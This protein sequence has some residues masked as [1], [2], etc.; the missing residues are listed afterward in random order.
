[1]TFKLR[2]TGQS[3]LVPPVKVAQVT[4]SPLQASASTSAKWGSWAAPLTG[5]VWR[6]LWGHKAKSRPEHVKRWA[7]TS[8]DFTLQGNGSL[9]APYNRLIGE[10]AFIRASSGSGDCGVVGAGPPFDTWEIK[11]APQALLSASPNSDG[12]TWGEKA[13]GPARRL[14][15]KQQG[16]RRQGSEGRAQG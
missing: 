5:S 15:G 6:L 7:D 10:T 14:R 4:S 1:M 3:E 9:S 16:V 13:P 11:G 8:Y 2:T 12:P